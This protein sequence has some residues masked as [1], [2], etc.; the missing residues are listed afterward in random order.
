MLRRGRRE[1][2]DPRPIGGVQTAQQLVQRAEHL[3]REPGRDFGLRVAARL[4]ERRQTSLGRVVVQAERR[5]QQLEAAEHRPPADLD[6]R[7]Q[8]ERQPAAGLA[9][10]RVDE[11]QAR[12][13]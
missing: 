5:Q 2:L 4:Q 12:H 6:Q 11:P 9:A 7:A 3:R 8:R 13:Q 1:R 10:R